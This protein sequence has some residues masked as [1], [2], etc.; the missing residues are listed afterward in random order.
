TRSQAAGHLVN[1]LSY[2][3]GAD[4]NFK[5]AWTLHVAA[6]AE[7]SRPCVVR[8]AEPRILCAANA[9]DMFNV[10]ECL[11]VVDDGLTHIKTQHRRKI[12]RLDSRITAFPLE[13]FD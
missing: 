9:H 1:Q 3:N 10:T 4:F 12:R 2:R 6:D 13:R 5:V 11:H 7:N 8:P